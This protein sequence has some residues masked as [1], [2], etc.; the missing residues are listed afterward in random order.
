MGGLVGVLLGAGSSQRLGRPKQTLPLGDTTGVDAPVIDAVAA[1]WRAEPSWAAVTSYRGV[2]GHPFVFSADAFPTL[3]G[4]HGDKAV[5]KVVDA[6][7]ET[8][9]RRV[10]VDRDVPRDIDT[11]DDYDAVRVAL[12]VS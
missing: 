10:A 12:G 7:P 6:E 3:R 9:V 1:A 8:R 4:L 5:W 11:W 2:L